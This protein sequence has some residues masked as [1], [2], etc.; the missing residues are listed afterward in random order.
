[1]Y[2]C[3]IAGMKDRPLDCSIKTVSGKEQTAAFLLNL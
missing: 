2:T 1:M 3:I